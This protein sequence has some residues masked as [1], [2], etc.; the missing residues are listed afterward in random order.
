MRGG[1]HFAP[2]FAGAETAVGHNS[3]AEEDDGRR[4]RICGAAHLTMIHRSAVRILT[5]IVIFV[6][7]KEIYS[8]TK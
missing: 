5:G 4:R 1:A 2:Q 7:A 8:W 6:C 3:W